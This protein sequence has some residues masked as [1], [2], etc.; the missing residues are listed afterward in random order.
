MKIT[1]L[2][3]K[4]YVWSPIV[5]KPTRKCSA[6]HSSCRDLLKKLFPSDPICEEVL[7]P[8]CSTKL[9]ADFYLPVRNLIVEVQ[10]K[11]HYEKTLFSKKN[12]GAAK[13]M[14][15]FAKL[16][17]RD[18]EKKELIEKNNILFVTLPYNKEAEWPTLILNSLR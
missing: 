12:V 16:R 2:N 1:G 7:L 4:E 11:Q 13:G 5:A 18:A 8:G 9:Y 14:L 6:L 10:G 15:A 3:G 17:S